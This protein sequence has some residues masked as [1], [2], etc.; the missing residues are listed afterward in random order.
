MNNPGLL[1]RSLR[2]AVE[3]A[4]LLDGEGTLLESNLAL[5]LITGYDETTLAGAPLLMIC[6]EENGV[7]PYE[8]LMEALTRGEMWDDELWASLRNGAEIPM[9]L[10]VTP[11]VKGSGEQARH[12]LLVTQPTAPLSDIEGAR[13]DAEGGGSHR[14]HL[15]GMPDYTL[16]RDRLHQALKQARH[17]GSRLAVISFDMDRFREINNR[18]GPRA[19]DEVLIE[20]GRRLRAELR[21][22]DTIAR[23]GGDDFGILCPGLGSEEI[24]WTVSRLVSCLSQPLQ[25]NGK[26]VEVGVS[27]GVAVFPDDGDGEEEL[28]SHS[29][30]A[31]HMAQKSGGGFACYYTPAM[32]QSAARRQV[33]ADKMRT[34]LEENRFALHYQP[35]LDLSTGKVLSME[36]LARWTEADGTAIP[37]MEFISVAEETGFI[38]T[39]GE[40][41]LFTA[42]RQTQE[43]VALGHEVRTAVNLS[44]R[45]FFQEDVLKMIRRALD[46]SGLAPERL[47]I[48]IT[49]SMMMNDVDAAIETLDAMREMGLKI[50]MDDFGTGYSSLAVLKRFPIDTLKVDRAF[51]SCLEHDQ[52]DRMIISTIIGM[53]KNLKL[54]VVA[55]GVETDSQLAFLRDEGCQEIQGYLYCKPLPAGKVADWLANPRYDAGPK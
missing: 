1:M 14:D 8:A 51:V 6:S 15:T 25:I 36:A 4:A 29:E 49:E 10:S 26:E 9:H 5:Q 31:V 40:W 18:L 44:A 43:W 38:K 2:H 30:I 45:Q 23:I 20:V 42:C 32:G 13:S 19:G 37:P 12:L 22:E 28:I 34:A 46:E 53:A 54:H 27:L 47:E 52:D 55:E 7:E 24:E 39:L 33:L 21:E 3:G 41:I 35:K 50:A 17:D 16:F 48:E 11:L